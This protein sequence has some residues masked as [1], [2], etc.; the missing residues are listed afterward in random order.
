LSTQKIDVGFGGRIFNLR[1]SIVDYIP[2]H[3]LGTSLDGSIHEIEALL[4]GI[5]KPRK[6]KTASQEYVSALQGF[7]AKR[8][9]IESTLKL[10]LPPLSIGT[11]DLDASI[12]H[13]GH[14]VAAALQF[15]D[16]E[17]LS[18]ELE[19]LKVLLNTYHRSEKELA[20]FLESYSNAIDA[21]INGQG[22]PIKKWLR[23]YVV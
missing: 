21:H 22:E 1:P 20:V 7:N 12:Q 14:N 10:S 15:G 5:S 16:M 17:H 9:H 23:K 18:E 2:G 11:E 4:Q 13:L 6:V 8:A 3:Y 19:W